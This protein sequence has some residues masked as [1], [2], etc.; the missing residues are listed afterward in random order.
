MRIDASGSLLSRLKDAETEVETGPVADVPQKLLQEESGLTLVE[1]L[2]VMLVMTIMAAIAL[3]AFGNQADKAKDAKAKQTAHTAL[4]TLETCAA[5]SLTGYE[6]CNANMLRT[7]EPTLP[8][9]PILRVNGLAA[10]KFTIVVR[11]EPSSQRFRIRLNA[12]GVMRFL[13]ANKGVG[14]CPSSGNWD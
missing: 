12:N 3:P 6:S 7:L 4:V 13:C 8:P 2:I 14:G 10:D 9:N 11:S 5:Q 1:L